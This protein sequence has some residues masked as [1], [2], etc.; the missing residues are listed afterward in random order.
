ME[1]R[2]KVRELKELQ[3][4][5]NN[6]KI[7]EIIRYKN[8]DTGVN[9]LVTHF[10]AGEIDKLM[11]I[12]EARIKTEPTDRYTKWVRGRIRAYLELRDNPITGDTPVKK[13]NELTIA[14]KKFIEDNA[15]HR[16]V[17]MEGEDRIPQPY[18]VTGITYTPRKRT[19][20][21]GV[22][23]ASVSLFAQAYKHGSEENIHASWSEYSWRPMT[24]RQLLEDEDLAVES[25]A[26]VKRYVEEIQNYDELRNACGKQ[27]Y[28][29]GEGFFA[30]SH[31]WSA[32]GLLP[33]IRD[34]QA[35][36]VVLDNNTEELNEKRKEERS[37]VVSTQFWDVVPDRNGLTETAK[38]STVDPDEDEFTDDEGKPEP[39]IDVALP[40]KPYIYV[41]DLDKHRWV[42]LH[43]ANLQE[44]PWDKTLM[45]KLILPEDHKNLLGVLMSKSGENI[46]DIIR[47]KM[48]GVIVLATGAPGAGKTLTAE[49][50]AEHIEKPLYVVQC[51]QLGLS[52]EH[53]EGNLQTI[54]NRASRWGAVLLIDEADVYI[55]TRGEDIVQNAIVGVFLRL[56][57]YY[58]GVLFMTS[59]RGN[60]I[61]DAILSRASAWVQYTLPNDELL[62]EI[63]SVLASQ[64]RVKLTKDEI[65]GLCES[66]PNISGRSVRNILKL[67]TML[68]GSKTTVADIL[69]MARY[70]ALEKMEETSGVKAERWVRS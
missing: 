6:E 15:P 52:V 16:W 9:V 64:Y 42:D 24:V 10:K 62:A 7:A 70:Q 19:R 69:N 60:I 48:S 57:E 67:A 66:L 20:H 29:V 53:I 34:G 37:R 56:L 41:F 46:G 63:W 36:R 22:I 21:D 11:A 39:T 30:G 1:I 51:S 44:Y 35:T 38:L 40:L 4:R 27:L 23:P 54:L 47:G 14:L 65:H 17:F 26:A 31:S 61:D 8:D 2:V 18:F 33:M 55:R 45:S 59:N 58:R 3:R 25:P 28:A 49:V 50:F 32:W 68:K 12:V 13:H 5:S 43:V